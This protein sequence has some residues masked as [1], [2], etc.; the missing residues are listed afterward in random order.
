MRGKE[1]QGWPAGRLRP[2]H[3]TSRFRRLKFAR[4]EHPV[5]GRPV[6]GTEY[7]SLGAFSGR[8]LAL[9]NRRGVRRRELHDHRDGPVRLLQRRWRA[10]VVSIARKPTPLP[11][12]AA[13]TQPVGL[14][15]QRRRHGHRHGDRLDLGPDAER[16]DGVWEGPGLCP[17]D[18]TRR[19]LGLEGSHHPRALLADELLGKFHG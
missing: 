8:L 9:C 19:P 3:V 4:R 16:A 15:G 13:A 11:G 14:P 18:P 5:A 17:R 2:G 6:E 1:G 12:R 10:H 7:H